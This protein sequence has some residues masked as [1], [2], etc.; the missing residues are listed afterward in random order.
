[1]PQPYHPAAIAGAAVTL[2]AAVWL[3]HQTSLQKRSS[4]SDDRSALWRTTVLLLRHVHALRCEISSSSLLWKRVHDQLH[5]IQ[6]LSEATV[7][8]STRD[9]SLRNPLSIY[10]GSMRNSINTRIRCVGHPRRSQPSSCML[11]DGSSSLQPPLSLSPIICA[12]AGFRFIYN[13]LA[14]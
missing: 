14:S 6:F 11:I 4:R 5:S 3:G 8:S 13:A 1:M 7:T 2:A 10:L 12:L 9:G